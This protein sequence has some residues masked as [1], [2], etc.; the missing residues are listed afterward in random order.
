[1]VTMHV[2][3]N[4]TVHSSKNPASPPGVLHSDYTG[5]RFLWAQA[6]GT[7]AVSD[8]SHHFSLLQTGREMYSAGFIGLQEEMGHLAQKVRAQPQPL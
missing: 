5:L 3:D 8:I 7:L 6:G 2:G 4:W 1:M